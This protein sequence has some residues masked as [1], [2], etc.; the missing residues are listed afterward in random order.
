MWTRIS[1]VLLLATLSIIHPS[2]ALPQPSQSYAP[3]RAIPARAGSGC[4]KSQFL[5][6]VTQYRFGLKSSGKDRSYSFHLP[7][8]YDKN[9]KHPVVVGF[10]GSS[11]V[12]L[13]FELDTK[14]SEARYSGDKI[15]IYPNGIDGSWAGPSYHSNSSSTIA[16][17]IQFVSDLLND[18]K[19]SFCV[20]DRKLYAVGMSNGG[21]FIGTLACDPVGSTLFSAYAA[22]SGAFYTDTNGPSN[23]CAPSPSALPIKMLEIH[24]AA[25]STVKYGGGQGDGGPQP[26]IASWLEWWAE[27]NACSQK[28]EESIADGKVTALKWTCG[29]TEGVLQH[30]RVEGLGHCWADTE[31]NLSQ[32]SVPQG[33][34]VMRASE[35]VMGFFAGV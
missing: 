17:D 16:E 29:G 2:S 9:R 8:G 5:P 7:A 12:G 1:S 27:R 10:H 3:P 13:F 33:P 14:M 15:M 35:I 18:V 26:P 28:K 4:G 23:N 21:G 22:H 30:Y 31:I 20:D 25:D 24:G 32:I 6:G 11:S 19:S 34:S